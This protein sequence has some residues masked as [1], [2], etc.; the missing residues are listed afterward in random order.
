MHFIID[1]YI[2]RKR[3]EAG[4]DRPFNT[5]GEEIEFD[6]NWNSIDVDIL[7]L[8]EN[9][10][11]HYEN[12]SKTTDP[13]EVARYLNEIFALELQNDEMNEYIM[14]EVDDTPLD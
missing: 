3:V 13:K 6:R 1:N 2:V 9:F 7:K 8:G 5:S 4:S 11:N 10:L 12:R 14:E